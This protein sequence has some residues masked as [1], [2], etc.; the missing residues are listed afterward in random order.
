MVA[1]LTNLWISKQE[2][3]RLAQQ[4]FTKNVKEFEIMGGEWW[5]RTEQ[6]SG[7]STRTI[8]IF[9]IIKLNTKKADICLNSSTETRGAQGRKGRHLESEDQKE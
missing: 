9:I 4:G 8:K 5:R 3:G 6:N 2:R 1:G 7:K